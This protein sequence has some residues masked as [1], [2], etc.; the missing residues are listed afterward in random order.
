MIQTLIAKGHA[1]EVNGSVYFD[2]TSAAD[3]GKLSNRKIEKQEAG[4]REVVRDDKRNPEDFALWKKAEPE[5]ILRW[6]SP[7]SEGFPGWH[8]ECSAMAKKYLGDTFDI[9]GGRHVRHSR[10]RHRQ[11][12]PA[13]RV[14]GGAKRVRQ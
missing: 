4:T 7:W 2:V 9:H 13:Q 8:I 12:V 6:D 14:R 5:H 11:S 1:Y 10:R 3:Y